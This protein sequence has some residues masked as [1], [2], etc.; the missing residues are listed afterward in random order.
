MPKLSLSEALR[1]LFAGFVGFFY[2][3]IYDAAMAERLLNRFGA[4]GLTLSLLV[5]S[6]LLYFV[7]RPLIYDLIIIRLQDAIR[8]RSENSRTY[9][10]QRYVLSTSEAQRLF[11]HV[12]DRHLGEWYALR[13]TE[14][15]GIHFLYLAGILAVPFLILTLVH[16]NWQQWPFFATASVVF[17]FAGFLLD[18]RYETDECGMIKSVDK[19]VV[20]AIARTQGYRRASPDA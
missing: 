8:F 4:L 6:A 7:Y 11:R 19:S 2:M 18:R 12:R 14:A 10:K 1:Y 20:D 5:A 13:A 3:F 9:L 17:F 15:S 16:R